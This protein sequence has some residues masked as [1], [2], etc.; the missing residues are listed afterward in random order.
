[1]RIHKCF[2]KFHALLMIVVLTLSSCEFGKEKNKEYSSWYL[3]DMNIDKLWKYS[4]GKTQT[5]AIIDSGIS[6]ELL[7][8]YEDNIVLTHNII[9]GTDDVTDNNGHGSEM[10]SIIVGNG[11][12]NI[13]GI[14]PKCN[15]M[16]IKIVDGEGKTSYEALN[17]ALK[18]AI[19][20]SATII[21]ISLGG[22]KIDSEIQKT[23]NDAINKGITIVAAAGDY[24]DRD[25][26]FPSN[27]NGV[28]SVEA[29]D[30]D[31]ELW[32]YSNS[33]PDSVIAFPG[34]NVNAITSEEN[35]DFVELCNGTSHSAAIASGY[36]ALLRDY[37]YQKSI[38]YNNEE[39]I[40][41]LKALNTKDGKNIN[42]NKA[43]EKLK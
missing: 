30:V 10:V 22:T 35:T 7:L 14:S 32:E 40:N 13:Y 29:I 26:L 31:N 15:V 25:L 41:I 33:S 38:A 18:Y 8:K 19:E 42:Y 39:L 16:I 36:I 17:N 27:I 12:L 5:I 9:D 28:I 23:I 37:M 11:Y 6:D 2:F 21:N 24:G 4:E 3:N 43:F 20:N 34:V 1:M